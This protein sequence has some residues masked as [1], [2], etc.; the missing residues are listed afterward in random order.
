MSTLTTV[1]SILMGLAAQ[2]S[3]TVTI[4]NDSDLVRE[5]GPVEITRQVGP[6]E[7][8]IQT[9]PAGSKVKGVQIETN[10]KSAPV[11]TKKLNVP[12][13]VKTET[14]PIKTEAAPEK[15][16]TTPEKTETVPVKTDNK[17]AP[18]VVAS[19]ETQVKTPVEETTVRS[20]TPSVPVETVKRAPAVQVPVETEQEQST[21]YAGLW[22]DHTGR[23]AIKITECGQGL[24]GNI[25]WLKSSAHQSVCGTSIIGD[26]KKVGN[27]YD[28][29]WIYDIDRGKKFDVELKLLT[30][31]KLR[32]KGYAGTKLLSKTMIWNRAPSDLKLCA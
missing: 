31:K 29:G 17:P 18:S 27:V 28:H 3:V 2:G 20:A 13:P 5:M 25:V 6:V 16:E 26:V 11:V 24:C 30:E 8:R 7:L 22:Y 32:V 4:P 1:K 19:Q 21:G 15:T 12:A 9:A 23:S 10:E 14:A